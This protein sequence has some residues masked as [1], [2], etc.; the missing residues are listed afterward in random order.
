MYYTNIILGSIA[1][2]STTSQQI[3]LSLHYYY[4]LYLCIISVL[5]H[6]TN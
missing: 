1:L 4:T 6:R 5:Y 3:T 2:I